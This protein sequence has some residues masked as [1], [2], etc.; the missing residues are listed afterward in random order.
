MTE[1]E[2]ACLASSDHQNQNYQVTRS[3]VYNFS[4]DVQIGMR[5]TRGGDCESN[6]DILSVE[7][8]CLGSFPGSPHLLAV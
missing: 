8:D 3:Q 5:S 7:S 4:H 6:V 1:T 2:W